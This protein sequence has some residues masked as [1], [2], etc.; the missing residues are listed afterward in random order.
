MRTLPASSDLVHARTR[1]GTVILTLLVWISEFQASGVCAS[2]GRLWVRSIPDAQ[3][4]ASQRRCLVL[5]HFWDYNCP[6]CTRVE[7][8]VLASPEVE[9]SMAMNFVAVRV[10]VTDSPALAEQFHIQQWPTDVILTA[11]GREVFRSVSQQ[12][13]VRYLAQLDQV[14]AHTRVARRVAEPNQ[15]QLPSS[16]RETSANPANVASVADRNNANWQYPPQRR[17]NLSPAFNTGPAPSNPPANGLESTRQQDPAANRSDVQWTS[18]KT[19]IDSG[20]IAQ[21]GP[22]SGP[23]QGALGGQAS[24]GA[25]PSNERSRWDRSAFAERGSAPGIDLSR[26]APEEN[27]KRIPVG[28]SGD[29]PPDRSVPSTPT[30]VAAEEG[31]LPS[32]SRFIENRFVKPRDTAEVVP[33]LLPKPEVADV[34]RMASDALPA[35]PAIDENMP[36]IALESY[37]AVTLFEQKR[38]VKGDPQFGARHRGRTYLFVGQAECDRFFDNPDRYSPMLSGYDP[39]LLMESKK[40]VPGLRQHGIWQDGKMYLFASEQSL[41]QFWQNRVQWGPAIEEAMRRQAGTNAR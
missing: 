34:S 13:P 9:R 30:D 32:D 1:L 21:K 20:V 19:P 23:T 40:W 37:C 6:P 18:G 39:V 31:N 12:D 15:Q 24:A 41:Q 17:A 36:P 2:D 8:N 38:W 11:D 4:L 5:V 26:T 27:R 10:N 25:P 35:P 28:M 33:D 7:R 16:S 29:V 3:Q 22:Y 14:A